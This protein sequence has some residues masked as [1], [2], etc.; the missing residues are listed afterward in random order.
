MKI[1]ILR[2]ERDTG[3]GTRGIVGEWKIATFALDAA[4]RATYAA[5]H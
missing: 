2:I 5:L 3:D 1:P 4:P